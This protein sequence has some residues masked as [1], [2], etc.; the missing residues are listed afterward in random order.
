VDGC[1]NGYIIDQETDLMAEVADRI[2][3]IFNTC[4][5]DMV[6]F[7][8]GEDV[9]RRRFRYYASNFQEQAMRRFAKRPI[10][11]MGTIMTHRLW[12][13]F[14]RSSTVD[15]YLNTIRGQIIGGK[16][17]A[18]WPTVK[19]H[20]N[21]SVRYMLEVRK[22]MM[23]GELGWFGIWPRQ[24]NTDGLQLDEIE[25]LMAKSLGYD[26]PVS[27]QT[28]FAS[29]G[30]HPLTPEILNIVR[31]YETLRLGEGCPE[32]V[33]ERLREQDRDVIMVNRAE[34]RS[35][36]DVKPVE[37]VGGTREVRAF[38]GE[39]DEGSVATIWHYCRAA[40]VTLP[41]APDE[42][43]MTDL[44]GNTLPWE[45][46]GEKQVVF[47]A[48]C[49][50]R[51]LLCPG[52]SPERLGAVL[53]AAT[54]EAIPAA[55]V[56]VQ[57][58]DAR[59]LVGRMALGSAVGIA[60][61]D[62]VGDVLVC[63]GTANYTAANPWYASYTVDIPHDGIW[64]VWGRVRY[65]SGGDDSFGIVPDGEEATLQ[66]NQ[67]LGNCGVN[68]KRWHWTG[69]GGGSTTVPPGAPIRIKLPK[70]PFSFRIYGR[71]SRSDLTL[72]PRLDMILFTDDPMYTPP[73]KGER[74]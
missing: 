21:R 46:T 15:T 31:M 18:E 30:A 67:V 51:T 36:V 26:V 66:G 60:E 4:G 65:P 1:I 10:V 24:E 17:P 63:T 28:S 47:T 9:D 37:S 72:T 64:W 40:R 34:G 70:G 57:A 3:G 20:I 27:L 35:F 53:G 71:E 7:D 33:R 19:Q 68:E 69:R 59:K 54:V 74:L 16:P 32:Q 43:E 44:L 12:H 13:S 29:M 22:S 45:E 49:H 5:F 23:P 25:Y 52:M 2:A 61:P 50:R 42:I 73:E 8:G 38:A 58:E 41:I 62:A 14:A 56:V 55:V 6:Y 48:D 39:L 11:H